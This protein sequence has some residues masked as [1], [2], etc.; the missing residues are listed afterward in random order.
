MVEDG[1]THASFTGLWV[2]TIHASRPLPAGEKAPVKPAAVHVDLASA[3]VMP[4]MSGTVWQAGVGVGRG[5]GVGVGRGVGVGVG[6][7]VGVGVGATGVGVAP[8][9]GVVP[10]AAVSVPAD[11]V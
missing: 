7:A 6:L 3:T 9:R 1:A 4:T 11:G 5:V 10:G 2:S 8:A